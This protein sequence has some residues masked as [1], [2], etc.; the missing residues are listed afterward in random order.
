M[1]TYT[2]AEASVSQWHPSRWTCCSPTSRPAAECFSP[3]LSLS[4][5]GCAAARIR[6]SPGA[7]PLSPVPPPRVFRSARMRTVPR[8]GDAEASAFSSFP[9]RLCGRPKLAV[10]ALGRPFL[11]AP[12]GCCSVR[13]CVGTRMWSGSRPAGTLR[14][15]GVRGRERGAGGP[16]RREGPPLPTGRS[17]A[18]S[19]GAERRGEAGAQ[20]VAAASRPR[21]GGSPGGRCCS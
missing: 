14:R 10:P 13:G 5:W 1:P 20:P 16:G 3:P 15:G 11:V 21:P 19:G 9:T 2:G 12:T 6:K 7:A 18:R 4:Q 8:P 17:G